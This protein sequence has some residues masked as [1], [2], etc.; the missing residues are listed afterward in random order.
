MAVCCAAQ[1]A[2]APQADTPEEFDAYL[3]VLYAATP[4]ATVAAAEAFLR[5]WPRSALRGHVYEREFEA[6]RQLADSPKAI[7]A[8]QSAL[9]AAPDN[10]VMLANLSVVLANATADPKR[11]A[12]AE[13][14]ARK[15]IELSESLRIPKFISPA[16]WAQTQARVKSQAHAALGLTANQRG[17]SAGAISEFESA[18]AVAPEPDASQLYR[19]G[20]LY[21]SAGNL[22][23]AREKFRQA[24][25]LSDTRIRELANRELR[26]TTSH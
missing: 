18:V 26:A 6:Y 9:S 21:R 11:L 7:Q 4:S 10:V 22:G 23:A 17:D 1:F 14:C 19:L 13:E 2:P 3:A 25:A 15:A 20:L 16:E 24:A 8:G 5:E 12:Q